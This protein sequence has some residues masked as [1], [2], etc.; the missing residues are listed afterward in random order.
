MK[1]PLA[2]FS[3]VIVLAPPFAAAAEIAPTF[4]DIRLGSAYEEAVRWA[5]EKGIFKGMPD[6]LFHPE[7]AVD[8]ATA[9]TLLVRRSGK[10]VA[11]V[12]SGST[13]LDVP[14]DAWY[15]GAAETAVAWKII[16][17][18][19]NRPN[20][21][22]SRVVTR[23]EFLKMLATSESRP[24]SPFP[25]SPDT[26][27]SS[28]TDFPELWSAGFLRDAY[29]RGVIDVDEKGA[30]S[31]AH[32]LTRGEI[33]ILLWR[34][35]RANNGDVGQILVSAAEREIRSLFALIEK[36]QFSSANYGVVRL[37]ALS[38]AMLVNDPDS[39]VTQGIGKITS[40]F[41]FILEEYRAGIRKSPS[42][43]AVNASKVRAVIE[44]LPTGKVFT[45][46]GKRIGALAA[47]LESQAS[48]H[49]Q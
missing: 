37:R 16:D 38:E 34:D 33:A 21:E 45:D 18:P 35:D 43:V 20:F 4:P 49:T 19:P 1:T 8:R 23:E 47:A 27:L 15:R 48:A 26:A 17:G 31:P 32:P 25:Y 39:S 2:L 44:E 6:G 46:L 36:K 11:A 10:E 14:T 22:P 13:F 28:D 3:A 40:A 30:L 42:E 9:L 7:D 5:S 12:G 29:L 41:A 24:V